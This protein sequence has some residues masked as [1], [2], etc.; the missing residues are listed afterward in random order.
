VLHVLIGAMMI[1]A[2]ST[3]VFGPFPPEGVAKFRLGDW[4][5][6]IGAGALTTAIL[7]LVPRTASLGVLLVSSF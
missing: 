2:D 1:F 7:P 4:I 3:K 6:V 5:M